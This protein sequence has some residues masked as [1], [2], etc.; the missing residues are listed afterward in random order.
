MRVTY[1]DAYTWKKNSKGLRR[2]KLSRCLYLEKFLRVK[3]DKSIEGGSIALE[4]PSLSLKKWSHLRV[5]GVWKGFFI[6][7]HCLG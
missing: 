7:S 4:K 1:N 2:T 6:F 3:G 5:R